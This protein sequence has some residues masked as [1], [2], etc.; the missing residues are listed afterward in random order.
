MYFLE[1]LKNSFV[2]C[3]RLGEVEE[4][5]WDWGGEVPVISELSK[6]RPKGFNLTPEQ[7]EE[8]RKTELT[9]ENEAKRIE[10]EA[11]GGMGEIIDWL[12]SWIM[13]EEEN[14]NVFKNMTEALAKQK[15]INLP[16]FSVNYIALN[17]RYITK[18]WETVKSVVGLLNKYFSENGI[19]VKL[20]DKTSFDRELFYAVLYFQMDSWLKVDWIVWRNT[21]KAMS[22][23]KKVDK[24]IDVEEEDKEYVNK[25]GKIN[26]L[27]SW[28]FD[29]NKCIADSKKLLKRSPFFA[30]W[31]YFEKFQ[32]Y[33]SMCIW[34]KISYDN[35]FWEE[36][37]WALFE[38]QKARWMPLWPVD[39]FV[40]EEIYNET[41]LL[42]KENQQ[43]IVDVA[44][45]R[46]INPLI[47]L[48]LSCKENQYCS[49]YVENSRSRAEWIF[50]M[51]P[52]AYAD[53]WVN[54]KDRFSVLEQAEAAADYFFRVKDI[55]KSKGQNP[56]DEDVIVAYHT[57]PSF[58]AVDSK[59][60]FKIL[61]G[62]WPIM[63]NLEKYRN[64]SESYILSAGVTK[65]EYKNAV[66]AYYRVSPKVKKIYESLS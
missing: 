39:N 38:Y 48:N 51:T 21:L 26:D 24:K 29:K 31:R 63:Y 1:Q 50:Q 2:R 5:W 27:D 6:F 30:W 25:D 53:I 62:N 56:S 35:S 46:G 17:Q 42:K 64:K 47:F 49:P 59:K 66:K 55:L 16:E 33:V 36:T 4:P 34:R 57:W 65:T 15:E 40:Q 60:F 44:R 13:E 43:I 41:E 3:L 9:R 19:D 8:N 28:D 45:R 32:V 10:Q 11:R 22:G 54:L 12:E 37:L 18:N 14:T 61:K 58:L 20:D 23:S 7:N 52:G